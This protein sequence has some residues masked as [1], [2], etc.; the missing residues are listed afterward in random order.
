MNRALAGSLPALGHGPCAVARARSIPL[1][2]GETLSFEPGGRH[3]MLIG[4]KRQLES[5]QRVSLTLIFEDGSRAAI[6]APVRRVGS[7]APGQEKGMRCGS[8]RCGGGK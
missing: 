5:G 3:I 2:A 7:E 6:D 8:G 4:L 1:P